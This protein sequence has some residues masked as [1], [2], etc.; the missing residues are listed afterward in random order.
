MAPT[1]RWIRFV[2]A[3]SGARKGVRVVEDLNV[4]V[5]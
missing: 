1:L 4:E 5:P 3:K 2:C